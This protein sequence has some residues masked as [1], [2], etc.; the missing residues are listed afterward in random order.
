MKQKKLNTGE[1]EVSLGAIKATGATFEE[2][3]AEMLKI[4]GGA[5]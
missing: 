5:C 4:L 3:Q 1:W 2:A